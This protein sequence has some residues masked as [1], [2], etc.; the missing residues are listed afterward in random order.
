MPPEPKRK[1]Y[2]SYIRIPIT[3]TENS[4]NAAAGTGPARPGVSVWVLEIVSPRYRYT[5]AERSITRITTYH[6]KITS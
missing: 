1:P 5:R 6:H 2:T 3:V 4:E